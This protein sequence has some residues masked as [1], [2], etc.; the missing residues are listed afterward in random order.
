MIQNQELLLN[1][2]RTAVLLGVSLATLNRIVS[3]GELSTIKVGKSVKFS[4]NTLANYLERSTSAG[5]KQSK[6]ITE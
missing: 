6:E 1:K 2:E 4:A 3:R 5:V